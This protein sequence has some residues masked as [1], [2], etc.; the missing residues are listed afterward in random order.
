[1]KLKKSDYWGSTEERENYIANFVSAVWRQY[2]DETLADRERWTLGFNLF[3][4]KQDWGDERE[5][6]EWM[7][8]PFL[9]EF[10]R[11]VRRSAD[12]MSGMVFEKDDFF[13]LI[14]CDMEN[15]GNVELARIMEKIVRADLR[16]IDLE[17][18]FSDFCIAAGSAGIGIFKLFVTTCFEYLPEPIIEE[19]DE[20]E[21]KER[22]KF[23]K[24]VEREITEIPTSAEEMDAF[25]ER[26]LADVFGPDG[27]APRPIRSAIKPKRKAVMRMKASVVDP[28]N[29]CFE[30]DTDRVK[31]SEIKLERTYK[32]IYQLE[33][34]FENGFFDKKKRKDLLGLKSTTGVESMSST[35]FGY[36]QQKLG[37]RDQLK[38]A[39]EFFP[40]I[41]MIEYFGPLLGK[42]GEV[43]EE[44]CH[45]V[46]AGG[47]V[48]LRDA[49]IA[50]WSKK[51]PY[52][53]AV[54][55]K[56]PFKAVGQGV[57][58]NAID[59]QLLI[60][61]LFATFLDMFRLAVYSPV[62]I[63][64]TALR[65]PEEVEEGFYPGQVIKTFGKTAG[66]VFSSVP[67]DAQP[68][69]L[70]FQVLQALR[71]SGEA[72]AGV[73]VTSANPSARARISATEVEA[74]MS[75]GNDSV[76][77]LGRNLDSNFVTPLIERVIEYR[78]QWGFE[79]EAIDALQERGVIT[80][81]EAETLSGISKIERF[82][83]LTR[84]FKVKIKGF[85]ERLERQAFLRNLNEFL[86]QVS[87][88]P[89]EV[90]ASI[91]WKALLEDAVE[92]FGFD[93]NRWIAQNTPQDKAA[94]ENKL[95]A[96][97]QLI[98]N[99]DDDMDQ[100]EL[101]VHFSALM[102]APTDAL[103]QH[104]IGHL[105][106]IQQR[107]EPLP[108]IPPEVQQLLGFQTEQPQPAGGPGR[109]LLI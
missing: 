92:A 5:E 40:T 60:N 41:E 43:L 89:P 67:Y 38:D 15:P 79:Q 55:C 23:P 49:E 34:A 21:E 53:I 35:V 66:E 46:V 77:A 98:S 109:Q 22:K 7:S 17:D 33:S 11:I 105:Q 19:I 47:K 27:A 59:Q 4:G 44:K 56:T 72:A 76:L 69:Q 63:D 91:Q 81:G 84:K 75:R 95:L 58:D 28:R 13:Q 30:P 37:T 85:R 50:S 99:G 18:L 80:A 71:V 78:L 31:T 90:L 48:V 29:F 68:G 3:N 14:P 16:D 9:H 97:G 100:L 102:S 103:V 36:D 83:E 32:R 93:Q 6:Q 45:F 70:I 10:S 57:A 106:R 39:S 94:E 24:D 12:A 8:R 64:D 107:G 87:Q 104:V 101:P 61:D 54:L 42:M 88:L 86:A 74:N 20:Q 26:E 1:M 62:V 25:I 73:D 2:A 82:R 108:Q 52:V 65:D 96:V 51:D